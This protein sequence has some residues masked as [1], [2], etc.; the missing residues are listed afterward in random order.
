MLRFAVL[1]GARGNPILF[2]FYVRNDNI[3]PKRVTLKSLAG[4]GGA[5]EPVI[6]IML[7]DED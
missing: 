5:S 6:T 7:P 2:E 1:A 3:G 4:P